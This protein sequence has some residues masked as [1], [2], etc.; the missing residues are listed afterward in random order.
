MDVLLHDGKFQDGKVVALYSLDN[1]NRTEQIM[2][3]VA[4]LTSYNIIVIYTEKP[5][6]MMDKARDYEIIQ[7][8]K[9][10]DKFMKENEILSKELVVMEE[11]IEKIL[12]DYLENEF[13]QMGSHITIYYDGDKWVLDENICTGI[14][15]DIV[16]NHFYSETVVINKNSSD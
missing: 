14:A 7:N 1:S 13:E 6:A 2:K 4:E 10:D 5:F 15:V 3:K 9:S 16:C 8:I 12:S 11:D